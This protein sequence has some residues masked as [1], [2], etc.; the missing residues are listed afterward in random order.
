ML[1]FA[2]ILA[3]NDDMKRF[4]ERN[5]PTVGRVAG[6]KIM[7]FYDDHAPPHVHIWKGEA[8]ACADILSPRLPAH[9]GFI[10]SDRKVILGW[11]RENEDALLANWVRAERRLPLVRI[12]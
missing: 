5:M 3:N 2:I 12:S 8:Q 4:A 1:A 9:T 10:A 11:I 7:I 6:A